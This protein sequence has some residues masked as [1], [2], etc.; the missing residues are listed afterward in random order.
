MLQSFKVAGIT[1]Y[2]YSLFLI[3]GAVVC[4]LMFYFLTFKRHRECFDEN[5]FAMQALVISMGIAVPSSM[6]ADSLFK[7]LE[8]GIFKLGGATFYGGLLAA[9]SVYSILLCIKK[10]SKVTVYERLSDLSVCI[11]AGHSLGRVGCFFGGCCF[12]KPTDCVFG[13]I[14]PEDSIPYNY[15]GKLIAVHPTQLYEAF[16][17]IAIFIFLVIFGKNNSFPLYLI[18]YGTVRIFIEFFRNDFRG[19]IG[20]PLSPAQLISLLLVLTGATV[21]SFKYNKAVGADENFL[22]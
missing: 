7:F 11:P 14:F 12:G 21:I 6:L 10:N 9:I 15:Y 8:S 20:L 16:L 5:L 19:S 17:L 2:P 22:K 3:A 13:V 18:L 4:F 1:F